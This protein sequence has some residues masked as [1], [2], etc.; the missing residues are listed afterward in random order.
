MNKIVAVFVIVLSV[1]NVS[2]TT[3][4]ESEVPDPILTSKKCNVHSPMSYGGYIYQ[5]P[6][7]YDQIFWPYTDQNGI[8]F[9][10]HS[11][12]ISFMS[13]FDKISKS[14]KK[15]IAK[16]LKQSFKGKKDIKSKLE[17][18]EKIYQLRNKDEEFKNRLTRTLAYWYEQLKNIEKAN[19]YRKTALT[20]IEQYLKQDIS[21]ARKFEYLY[22]AANYHRQFGNPESS[23]K[24][25]K[26]LRTK[27]SK[28][29]KD[30][31]LKDFADYLLKLSEDTQ[32]ITP[33]GVLMPK[34][35]K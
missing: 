30:N 33:D 18:L 10:E 26:L 7:K 31:K 29:E 28:Q 17:L 24:Y 8:W 1:Q 23:D 12:F 2:A 22:L 13:D 4:G 19:S 9:C 3:W 5:W 20:E 21:E 35:P 15:S 32:Y 14:E 6:S 25:L 16:Y 34:I 27:I 11:G